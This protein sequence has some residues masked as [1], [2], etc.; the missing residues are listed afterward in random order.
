MK[1][2]LMILCAAPLLWGC[3]QKNEIPA[4]SGKVRVEVQVQADGP[5]TVTRATCEEAI[6]DVNLYLI[7][8]IHDGYL[9]FYQ[10]EP[11]LHFECL[12]GEY[13][14]FLIVNL[15]ASITSLTL[16]E[17][18]GYTLAARASYDDLPMTAWQQVTIAS[19]A[20]TCYL[21]PVRARRM[22]ARIDYRITVA[23]DLPIQIRGVQPMHLPSHAAAYP[24]AKVSTTYY[25]APMMQNTGPA[26]SFTG[27]FYMLPNEQGTRPITDQKLKNPQN[28]P[29]DA[30][31]L[32]I[33]AQRG[34]SVVEYCVFLGENNTSDFNVR[35]NTAHTYEITL[36]GDS[37]ADTRIHT[38]TV[39]VSCGVVGAQQQDG[40]FL[41][42][43]RFN[44]CI[45]LQGSIP[46]TMLRASLIVRRG[47]TKFCHSDMPI[48]PGVFRCNITPEEG[49]YTTPLDYKLPTFAR[50]NCI[51]EFSVRIEDKDGILAEHDFTFRYAL[52]F[53]VYT[54][55]FD[56]ANGYGAVSS[57]DAF[58]VLP[59]NTLSAVYYNIYGPAE[60]CTLH[61]EPLTSHRF[62]G[63]F[64]NYDSSGLISF[65]P[66]YF[67]TPTGN[68]DDELYAYFE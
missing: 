37:E 25:D 16:D 17:L 21:P 49:S 53:R 43:V 31:W 9:H 7:D 64:R 5:K 32:R 52:R 19:D 65:D 54:R 42:P 3:T 4:G 46:A 59:V 20:A 34:D 1:K 51:L 12:S 67:Y 40:F 28:A 47:N 13:E 11:L 27:S 26:N 58:G 50:E 56:G 8:R 68:A 55:W 6:A 14:L 61:A 30:S 35:A 60:G 41:S 36:R 22:V 66:D 33:R 29:H 62:K 38:Y 39:G 48:S 45:S 15:H 63:W 44:I 18:R 23:G 24:G 2:I 57:P 10:T